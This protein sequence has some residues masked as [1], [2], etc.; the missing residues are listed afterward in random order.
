MI[1]REEGAD[2]LLIAQHDHALIAGELASH[3][4]NDRF[5]PPNP[6]EPV[7]AGVRLHDCGWPTHDDFPTINVDG[8]PLDVFEST[9]EIAIKA[10]TA[11]AER[12]AAKDPYAGLLTSLHVL[13]LSVMVI[14]QAPATS[15]DSWNLENPATRFA[16]VKFQHKQIE[17]QEQLRQKLG[18]RSDR[19]T[20]TKQPRESLQRS[21]DQL[22]ANLHL[23]Q[24]MDA[25]SLAICCTAPPFLTTRELYTKPAGPGERLTLTRDGNNL[26]ITPWPFDAEMI[27]LQ[28]ACCRIPKRK[29]ESDDDLREAFANGTAEILTSRVMS[30]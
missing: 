2:Y 20:A 30:A 7:V 19:A 21:E 22:R 18:L 29:Y 24:V 13:A 27:E 17:L 9:S 15:N 25:V 12:A 23:L 10:W 3:V 5:A 8:A 26:R 28:I 16:V 1:R 11:S 14:D 6:Y 4:G